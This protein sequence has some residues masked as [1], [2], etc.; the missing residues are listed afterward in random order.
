[1][2]AR[3]KV[4]NGNLQLAGRDRHTRLLDLIAKFRP[5]GKGCHISAQAISMKDFAMLPQIEQSSLHCMPCAREHCIET[6][7]SHDE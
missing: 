5:R 7:K 6:A 3:S 1:M 2:S 4:C